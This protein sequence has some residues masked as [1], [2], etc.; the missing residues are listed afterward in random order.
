MALTACRQRG[1][2]SHDKRLAWVPPRGQETSCSSSFVAKFLGAKY[3][4]ANNFLHLARL[5]INEFA[6]CTDRKQPLNLPVLRMRVG[7][8]LYYRI[9]KAW[10]VLSM[11][12][13]R[14][15][16]VQLQRI[17]HGR[18][19]YF[20]YLIKIKVNHIIIQKRAMQRILKLTKTCS[21]KTRESHE[22]DT[23]SAQARLGQVERVTRNP[24]AIL[25]GHGHH[26]SY[27]N[28]QSCSLASL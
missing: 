14:Q 27:C 17:D 4:R 9:G 11:G 16:N 22:A 28:S 8:S 23:L 2:H 18:Y 3:K 10:I 24:A 7:I 1:S 5:A 15:D 21:S 19:L 20:T 12:K 26:C 6:M 13:G 25:L